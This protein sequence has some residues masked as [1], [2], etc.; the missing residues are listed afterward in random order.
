MSFFILISQIFRKR[1]IGVIV[2]H[3][4]S[5]ASILWMLSFLLSLYYLYVYCIF[6]CIW[7]LNTVLEFSDICNKLFILLKNQWLFKVYRAL[8]LYNSVLKYVLIWIW[9]LIWILWRPISTVIS[10]F[11]FFS[12]ISNLRNH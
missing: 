5:W 11:L 9:N 2:N 4:I 8:I 1:P 7:I 10:S 12:T 3:L 6:I